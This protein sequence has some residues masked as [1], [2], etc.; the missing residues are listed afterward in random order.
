MNYVN[1]SPTKT[2]K[3]NKNMSSPVC[4]ETNS[5]LLSSFVDSKLASQSKPNTSPK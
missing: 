5:H 4:S 1:H 2:I 3:Q